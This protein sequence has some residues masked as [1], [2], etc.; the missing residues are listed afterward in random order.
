MGHRV[1]R[2][3]FRGLISGPPHRDDLANLLVSEI[4]TRPHDDSGIDG[5]QCRA[6]Q[7]LFRSKVGQHGS[8]R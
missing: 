1:P 7:R 4:Q 8:A 2:N 3:P 6:Q 5:K